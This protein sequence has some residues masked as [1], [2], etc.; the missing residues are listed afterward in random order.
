MNTG[1]APQ[2]R[3]AKTLYLRLLLERLL[4]TLDITLLRDD[5]ELIQV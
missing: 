2:R 5:A 3:D 1:P 4:L